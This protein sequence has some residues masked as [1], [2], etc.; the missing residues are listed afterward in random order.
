[1]IS[2]IDAGRIYLKLSLSLNGKAQDIYNE[3]A[4]LTWKMISNY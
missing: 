3:I 1:M 2:E 4:I